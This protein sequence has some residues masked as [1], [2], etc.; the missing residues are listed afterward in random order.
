MIISIW[1]H[2]LH[3]IAAWSR[4]VV[5]LI[6]SN[7]AFLFS[8]NLFIIFQKLTCF[9]L[10]ISRS[11]WRVVLSRLLTWLNSLIILRRPKRC[12]H[13]LWEVLTLTDKLLLTVWVVVY[14]TSI[15]LSWSTPTLRL[16]C[17]VRHY[18][19]SLWRRCV[20]FPW[21]IW[22]T[23]LLEKHGVV[24]LTLLR[25]LIWILSKCIQ[26]IYSH[27]SVFCRLRMVVSILA[28]T[29]TKSLKSD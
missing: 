29:Y 28:W 8:D 17:L 18:V 15:S 2:S 3:Q 19:T 16:S 24:L 25:C 27:A 14:P 4:I 7:Y 5:I 12:H 21:H 11:I 9:F 10:L 6:W 20:H 22:V 1:S 26:N 23:F 13:T